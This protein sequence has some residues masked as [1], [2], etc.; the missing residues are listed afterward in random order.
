MKFMRP[1][2]LTLDHN[3]CFFCAR[4]WGFLLRPFRR[5]AEIPMLRRSAMWECFSDQHTL[6]SVGW[7][8]L[9]DV[10]N[11]VLALRE[12]LGTF[13]IFAWGRPYLSRDDAVFK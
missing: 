8:G 7:V 1:I 10:V 11:G 6:I 5:Y 4:N 2:P 12:V 3:F 13:R 9:F